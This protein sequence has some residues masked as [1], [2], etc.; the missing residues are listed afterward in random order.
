MPNMEIISIIM[1]IVLGVVFLYKL[2]DNSVNPEY[3]EWLNDQ[4]HS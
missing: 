2:L 1:G 4:D 3:Q